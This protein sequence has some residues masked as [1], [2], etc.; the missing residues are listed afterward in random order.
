MLISIDIKNF[1]CIEAAH[2][3]FDSR[4]TG[5]VGRNASGKTSLLEAIY[6]LGHG[7]SFRSAHRDEL[8]RAGTQRLRVIGRALTAQASVTLGAE[9]GEEGGRIHIAGYAAQGFAEVASLLPI[10]VIDPGVHRVIEEGSSKRRRLLDWGVFH[11][12]HEFIGAWRRYQRALAQRNAA[13]KAGQPSDL[14]QAWDAELAATAHVIDAA[15]GEYF[16]Q[17]AV[18]FGQWCVELVELPAH[19]EYARGWR[20]GVPFEQALTDAF[21]RDQRAKLTSVGPHRADIIFRLDG[22][23]ARQRISRG[24]QKMLASAFVLALISLRA[25][26]SVRPTCLLLDDPAAELDVD[27]LGKLLRAL[28]R[29]P[30]QLVVTAVNETGLQGLAVGRTFHV[31]HGRVSYNSTP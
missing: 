9:Y 16:Q 10:Q 17:L 14:A 28:L 29:L 25:G 24:Q 18:E 13:L 11:V 20:A 26:Q 23:A 31:E 22:V 30:A 7:K 27:N 12:K 6:F 1:R 21:A 5:I 3:E 2:L 15:R 19:I 8:V 4:A